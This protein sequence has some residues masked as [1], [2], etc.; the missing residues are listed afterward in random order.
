[1]TPRVAIIGAGL[2][3]LSAAG[4]L[5][6]R[7]IEVTLI[8][9]GRHA[10]GRF[11]TRTVRRDQQP[12]PKF[13]IGPQVLYARLMY[14]GS[15]EPHMRIAYLPATVPLVPR[16]PGRMC[17]PDEPAGQPTGY[18]IPG[19]VRELPFRMLSALHDTIDFRDHTR[20]ERLTR[21]ETGWRIETRSLRDDTRSTVTAHALVLTA[22]LPQALELLAAS[23]IVLP[24]DLA[25]SL[26]AVTY[27]RRI[28]LYGL[29][30][31]SGP[32]PAGV[33]WLAEGPLEWV[34]DNHAKGVTDV[35]GA[36]TAVTS[37]A[38]A[39]EHW[40]EPDARVVERLMP[41]VRAW[42]GEPLPEMPVELH[43][44]RWATPENPVAGPCAVVRDLALV[45]A[46]D[47]FAGTEPDPAD[48]ALL[49]GMTAGIRAAGLVTA[50]ARADDRFTL[51]RPRR[52]VL[53]AAVST[54]DDA[55][56]ATEAGADRLE[57]SAGL[58]VGG[59]TPSL[60]VFRAVRDVSP[61]PVWVMLRPRAGGFVYTQREYETMLADARLFVEEGAA[62][63]VFG[64]LTADGEIDRDRCSRLV[65]IAGGR[66]VFHRAFD[67]VADQFL[68]LDDLIDLGFCRVLTSGGRSTA[69]AGATR[70]A[71]LVQHAGWLI[72]VLPAGG[73]RPENA[74]D[75]V[76]E[77]RCDQVHTS[78]RVAAP[79]PVL[80]ANSRLAEAVGADG[81]GC[82]SATSV[83]LVAALRTELDR[84][85]LS[86]SSPV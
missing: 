3:G 85:A 48:S 22:P 15:S 49:S 38:W 84:V 14:R 79:D 33:A 60:G 44:W 75:L 23:R 35:K 42:V 62:G 8:D 2:A 69:E 71:A 82:H 76:R 56:R 46:G 50:L 18:S 40:D 9:K 41:A 36:Y 63:L 27:T 37:G 70:L 6:G 80:R 53:E 67:L 28:A 30:S 43:R 58:E 5:L 68:A 20:A 11:C 7:G 24:D 64:L 21:T 55:A 1:M 72:E 66:A 83:E 81:D 16:A 12:A 47:G 51:A 61:L 54:P 32:L 73:I 34:S 59:L 39:A 74:A 78:A 86:L 25:A 57:L 52:V 13:D 65:G 19:G 4:Q 45:L 77:T 26:R 29:F 31:G 17:G 10:G